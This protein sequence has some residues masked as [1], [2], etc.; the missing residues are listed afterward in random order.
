MNRAC[1]DRRCGRRQR[2][3]GSF[4]LDPMKLRI[5]KT[6]AP[7][8]ARRHR[9]RLPRSPRTGRLAPSVGVSAT[10]CGAWCLED[11]GNFAGELG[12]VGLPALRYS[13]A[14]RSAVADFTEMHVDEVVGIDLCLLSGESSCPAYAVIAAPSTWAERW[15]PLSLRREVDLLCGELACTVDVAKAASPEGETTHGG[16]S[17]G[18]RS[19]RSAVRKIRPTNSTGHGGYLL[20]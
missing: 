14:N 3:W 8:T 11:G 17:R 15:R 7:K 9:G 10:C 18:C 2:A 12:V 5:S 6:K 13:A 19:A 1:P 20:I 4:R 16:G